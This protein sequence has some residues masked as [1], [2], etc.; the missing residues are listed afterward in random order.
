M[1]WVVCL[2]SH[3]SLWKI[4]FD[5]NNPLPQQNVKWESVCVQACNNLW[6]EFFFAMQSVLDAISVWNPSEDSLCSLSL[7]SYSWDQRQQHQA[8]P[9]CQV[10][11]WRASGCRPGVYY[12]NPDSLL[13]TGALSYIAGMWTTW[14][15]SSEFPM[16]AISVGRAFGAMPTVTACSITRQ[17]ERNRCAK[18][19]IR[20]LSQ[21]I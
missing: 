18:Q 5:Q 3:F 7:C 16:L 4:F 6:K 15:W 9:V 8:W 12:G 21:G 2:F 11:P 14:S 13:T 20:Y 19:K 17:W 10:P 1:S